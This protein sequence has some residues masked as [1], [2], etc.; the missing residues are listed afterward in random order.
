MTIL[1]IKGLI[2]TC[3]LGCL[4]IAVVYSINDQDMQLLLSQL[5]RRFPQPLVSLS[6]KA[7]ATGLD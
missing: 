4:P 5:R 1:S 3:L 7:L 2:S 6:F